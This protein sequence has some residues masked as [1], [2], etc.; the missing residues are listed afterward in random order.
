M[1]ESQP[2]LATVK[3]AKSYGPVAA[4]QE[5]DFAVRRGEVHALLGAN[6]AGKSTLVKIL[7][8]VH[9]ADAGDVYVDGRPMRIQAPVDA[10]AVGHVA[11]EGDVLVKRREHV[12]GYHQSADHTRLPRHQPPARNEIGV[13]H[14]L[15]RDVVASA[16]F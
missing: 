6:G 14:R 5:V 13:H 11:L 9:P 15:C 8:G 3:V 4:L 16:I 12:A 7:A 1:S 2:L 10:I